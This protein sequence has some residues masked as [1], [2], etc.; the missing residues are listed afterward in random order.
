MQALGSTAMSTSN[1]NRDLLGIKFHKS[2]FL[3]EYIMIEAI[4]KQFELQTYW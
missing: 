3:L 4:T 1:W 2:A